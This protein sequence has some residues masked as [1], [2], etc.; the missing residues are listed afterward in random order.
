MIL[1]IGFGNNL[2]GQESDVVKVGY[3][4]IPGFQYENEDGEICGYNFD[5]LRHIGMESKIQFEYYKYDNFA[6]ACSA[7]EQK[8]ID[9]LAP[10]MKTPELSGKFKFSEISLETEYIV[11]FTN[12]DNDE[13]YYEDYE[14]FD[15]LKVGVV[16]DYPTEGYFLDYMEEN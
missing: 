10:V 8:E 7:L 1:N 12:A 11:L 13:L 15:G 9:L 14:G 2:Y 3:Y 6:D 16:K 4:D 5:L